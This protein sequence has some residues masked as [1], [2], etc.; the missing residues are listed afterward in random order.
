L[1]DKKTVF[2]LGAGASCP[3]GYPSGAILRKEICLDFKKY[4]A[5]LNDNFSDSSER[6][7]KLENIQHF[8]KV[9]FKS[10]TPSIDL[11][12]ARN[13]HLATTGKYIIA[14]KI[15]D[16][17]H[18]SRFNE[19]AREGQDWCFYLFNR[20]TESV[21]TWDQ[22]HNVSVGNIRFVTFNYDRSLEY[23]LYESLHNSFTNI[24]EHDI[25]C[26]L[27]SIKIIHVYGQIAPLKWQ[28]PA[29][30]IPYAP[31][32]TELLLQNVAANIRTIYEERGNPELQDAQDLI[33]QAERIFFL[34][35]GY[36]PENMEVLGLPDLIPPECEVYG[37]AYS[38][39]DSEVKHI[40]D[41]LHSGRK[42]DSFGYKDRFDNTI[43]P[44][45]C[46]MILRKY[47]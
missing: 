8:A 1:I 16:A 24:P 5:Y 28:N 29:S 11:F 25:S 2:V 10:S 27:K 41:I 15:F 18:S 44:L 40:Q 43:E 20:L 36:A 33:R 39:M 46:L 6:Q 47:L 3:Y 7:I 37:T 30:Y 21:T 22:F 17:E 4:I 35:F 23:Y 31:K 42:P 26:L 38:M 45:D 13:P 34:G 14:F 32:F 9:F 12:L 19:E